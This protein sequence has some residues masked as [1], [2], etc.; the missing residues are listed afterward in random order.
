MCFFMDAYFR[1]MLTYRSDFRKFDGE[2]Y[3]KKPAAKKHFQ[4]R[5]CFFRC[6]KFNV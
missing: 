5:A 3:K 6:E 2:I 1:E 4:P